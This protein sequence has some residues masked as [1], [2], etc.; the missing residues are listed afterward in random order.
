M[1]STTKKDY[2][3]IAFGYKF[4]VPKGSIVTSMTASGNDESYHFWDD[5]HKLAQKLTGF[6]D[7]CLLH[8]LKYYG[9]NIPAEFCNPYPSK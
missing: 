2:E 9:L 6:S 3:T 5:F 4:T 1:R 7:S 8:D